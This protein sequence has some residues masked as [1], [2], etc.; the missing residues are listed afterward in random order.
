[1]VGAPTKVDEEVDPEPT[2]T[3]M[4]SLDGGP[5]K[6]SIGDDCTGITNPGGELPGIEYMPSGVLLD[7]DVTRVSF[8][9]KLI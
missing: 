4:P 8:W 5:E 1:M 9:A 3:P 6:P 7:I 2:W